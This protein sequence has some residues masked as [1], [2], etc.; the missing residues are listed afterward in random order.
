MVEGG[1]GLAELLLLFWFSSR[2]LPAEKGLDVNVAVDAKSR[3]ETRN[4]CLISFCCCFRSSAFPS[5]LGGKIL[6]F[7]SNHVEAFLF[8]VKTGI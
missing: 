6:I 4:S 3:E 5:F 1:G 7:G 2:L 8:S